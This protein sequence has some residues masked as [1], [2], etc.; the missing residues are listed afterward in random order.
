MEQE[1][2]EREGASFMVGRVLV[3]RELCSALLIISLCLPV[4]LGEGQICVLA[5]GQVLPGESPIQQWFESDPLIDY[6]LVPTDVDFLVG[7]S[8]AS[9]RRFVRLYFPR[10]REVLMEGFDFMVFPDGRL[11]PFTS[12]QIVDMKYAVENGLGSCVTMGGG[13]ASPSRN[14]YSSWAN[15]VLR[16][17]L[18]VE[19]NDRMKHDSS[20]F[21]IEV[22]KDDPP[23][24]SMFLPLGIEEFPGVHFTYLTTRLGATVWANLKVVKFVPEGPFSLGLG[25]KTE[26]LVSWRVG[27]TGGISWALA[28]DLDAMWWSSVLSP[29]KNEYAGDVFINILLY[30]AGAPMTHDIFQLHMLR[31]L[32]FDYNVEKSLLTGVLEFADSFGTSTRDMYVRVD[33]VNELRRTS[34]DSY[35][36]YSFAEATEIMGSAMSRLVEL[37]DDAFDLKDRA[38]FWIYLTQWVTVTGTFLISGFLV[39]T[40]MVRRRLYRGVTTTRLGLR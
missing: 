21:T 36:S 14:V 32:Y 1:E 23:V 13:L 28:D 18:P 8:E 34:L 9:F 6:V 22:V 25:M 37:R 24:L 15:S 19:L 35:R 29:S 7:F 31:R 10:T 27:A 38:L 40:L 20:V 12:S 5:I 11:E 30:S 33:E 16:E 39:W 17:I 26:W 3:S 2:E 4:V